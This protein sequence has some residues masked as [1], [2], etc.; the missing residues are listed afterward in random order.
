M[1]VVFIKGFGLPHDCRGF[2]S[3]SPG[4]VI[5]PVSPLGFRVNKILMKKLFEPYTPFTK[6]CQIPMMFVTLAIVK[7]SSLNIHISHFGL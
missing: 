1:S 6:Q 7:T 5:M 4:S 2:R 3:A